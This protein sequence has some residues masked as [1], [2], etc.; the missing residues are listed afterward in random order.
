MAYTLKQ[1]Q[2]A[3]IKEKQGRRKYVAYGLVYGNPRFPDGYDIHTSY[4]EHIELC[5]N[6]LRLQTENSVYELPFHSY[7]PYAQDESF[8]EDTAIWKEAPDKGQTDKIKEKIATA[9]KEEKLRQRKEREGK[10]EDEEECF[11]MVF[12]GNDSYYFKDA[13]VKGIAPDG[14]KYIRHFEQLVH[15]GMFQDS[16]LLRC[17][18]EEEHLKLY[19]GEWKEAY[20]LSIRDY[21]F[22]FFPYFGNHIEFYSWGDYNKSI[23]FIN[24]GQQMLR[25][26]TPHGEFELPADGRAYR[27]WPEATAPIFDNK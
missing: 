7:N 22:R 11:V 13:F 5:E 6:F 3:F 15:L 8:W 24:Q 14:T 27:I 18:P 4:I 19:G 10:T 1:W 21:D 20:E 17:E 2:I 23:Y 9:S 12:D 25:V 26:T 16:V